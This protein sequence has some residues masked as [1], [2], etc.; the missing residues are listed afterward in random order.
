MGDD[1]EVVGDEQVGEAAL[2][3]QVDQQIEDL[4]LDRHVQRRGRLVQQ[5]DLGL[6]DQGAGDRHP[7][8]LAARELVRVAVAEGGPSP[9]SRNAAS[10]RPPTRSRP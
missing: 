4:R 10:T 5:H 2:A 7:L 3:A 9:T 6:Q 1:G 8:P